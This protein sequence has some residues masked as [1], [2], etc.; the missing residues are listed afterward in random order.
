[1]T[2]LF[3]FFFFSSAIANV[4]AKIDMNEDRELLQNQYKDITHE[5]HLKTDML[6]KYKHK[7]F[8]NYYKI[9]SNTIQ[10]TLLN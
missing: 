3:Y 1:M 2:C 4:L 6:R 8:T 9:L 5:L 10:S 7:V